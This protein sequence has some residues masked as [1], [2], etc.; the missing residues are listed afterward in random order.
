MPKSG[1]PNDIWVHIA[2]FVADPLTR[3]RL[4]LVNRAALLAGRRWLAGQP[5]A[6]V[7]ARDAATHFMA[8]AKDTHMR[9]CATMTEATY[10][11]H[12]T[13]ELSSNLAALICN[14]SGRPIRQL[15]ATDGEGHI[16]GVSTFSCADGGLIGIEDLRFDEWSMRELAAFL[17]C[18][19]LHVA[20]WPLAALALECSASLY[21]GVWPAV[22]SRRYPLVP[23]VSSSPLVAAPQEWVAPFAPQSV[24][25]TLAECAFLP[26]E[27]QRARSTRRQFAAGLGILR[28]S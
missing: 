26:P 4:A 5:A 15:S 1:P 10:V 13:G 14:Y 16:S 11:M 20:D 24:V 2:E 18:A 25:C 17:S 7:L 21:A 28:Y 6:A 23:C 22:K 12:L 3:W 27:L 8:Q 19:A 9:K